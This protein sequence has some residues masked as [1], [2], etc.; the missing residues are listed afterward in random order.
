MLGR[1]KSIRTVELS[2]MGWMCCLE[3]TQLRDAKGLEGNSRYYRG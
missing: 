1:V 2:A 3:R